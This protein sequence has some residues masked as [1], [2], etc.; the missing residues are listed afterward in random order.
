METSTVDVDHHPQPP[1]IVLLASPG[2]GHLI[3]VLELGIRLVTHHNSTVT[4][5]VVAV[6]HSSPA[7][8]ALILDATA[9]A[10]Y[11]S[12][13]ILFNVVKLPA[14]DISNLVDQ[15]AAVVT[16][17]C[18]LMRETKPTL[19][20]AMRSLEVLPAAL[21]VD[22]FGTESFVI[23]DEMGIGKYLLGT[24]NAWFTALTLHTPALD[25]EVDGQYVDQT[26]PLTIPGCRLVRPDEVV[27]P[28]LDRNDMQY[29]EYKRIGAEFAKAD[30]ILINTWEDL[31]P[32]TLAALRN[33]KFFGGSVIKGDVLSIGPLVRPSNNNQKGPTDDDELFS[34]LDKQPKQSVIYVSFGSAGTLSTHQLNELAHGL[35]LS[36]QRFVWV[37]RRPTDFKDSAYF[38]FGG[39]DEIPGRLNYLPDGFLERTR[40]V[41]MVVPNWA[42]QAEVLCHP[43]V[44]W[45][46]SH[47]G[48][49]STLESVTNNV[50]MVVW[51]MYAEQRMNSTLLAEELKVAARTKTMPWRGVVGREEIGEL[52]KKVMVGEEGVLIRE[53]VNEVKCSGEKALKEGS[54]SSFKALAS[55]VDKCACRYATKF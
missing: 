35:E 20:S 38:T 3:P 23:A 55:V 8:A 30:A 45:F 4:V 44:G 6:D 31:E 52:V 16:R 29:V 42:P 51:P 7:E 10:H 39:S 21:V 22:L 43:S 48:W 27:D 46:L 12:K 13:N 17:I 26:E 5:F 19:R 25:K 28:M 37:V 11:S 40:D 50:P 32:S 33:D 41:G 15:E 18:V 54:G 36:K 1:H 53:K 14:P 2:T 9:R 47:C 24:S 49:N 34:W